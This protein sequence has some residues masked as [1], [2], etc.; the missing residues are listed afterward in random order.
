MRIA[1]LSSDDMLRCTQCGQ[2]P[3][4]HTKLGLALEVDLDRPAWYRPL[5]RI[6]H[7]QLLATLDELRAETRK[8]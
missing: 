4:V 8:V 7:K 2:P 5:R 1:I 6:G 3:I